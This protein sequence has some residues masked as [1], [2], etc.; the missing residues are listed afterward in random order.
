MSLLARLSAIAL[1]VAGAM[2]SPFLA[3]GVSA[4]SVPSSS[5]CYAV[6]PLGLLDLFNLVDDLDQQSKSAS[7]VPTE[8]Y[9]PT[10]ATGTDISSIDRTSVQ[11]VLDAFVACVNLRDPQRLLTLLSNRYQASLVLDTFEGAD[12]MSAIVHQ[13]PVIAKADDA[14]DPIATPDIVKAWHPSSD[15]T[16]I[17]AVISGPI[18]G[19]EGDVKLFVVF[20]PG[21]SGWTI[22]LVAGYSE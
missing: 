15:P 20:V 11:S 21:E 18:P 3:G 10:L 9:G 12:V 6:K 4:G 5:D 22:D 19:Y 8:V 17:W 13:I 7:P 14:S 16:Q 1:L 2:L